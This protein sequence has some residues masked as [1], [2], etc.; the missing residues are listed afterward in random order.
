MRV[1]FVTYVLI[2]VAGLTLFTIIG[3]THH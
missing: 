3:L 2:V 1:M